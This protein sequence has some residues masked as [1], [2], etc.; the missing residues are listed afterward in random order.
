MERESSEGCA[1][2]LSGPD[3]QSVQPLKIGDQ[4]LPKRWNL[5]LTATDCGC[6]QYSATVGSDREPPKC[7]TSIARWP[8]EAVKYTTF[9]LAPSNFSRVGYKNKTTSRIGDQ[10]PLKMHIDRHGVDA[11][12]YL[13]LS[14]APLKPTGRTA[15][16]YNYLYIDI[17]IFVC[18]STG[19]QVQFGR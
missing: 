10:S 18:P 6:V 9:I 14:P 1:S 16:G 5:R 19:T 13:A 12:P 7:R 11:P 17:S 4:C 15:G 8:A 2:R 3:A